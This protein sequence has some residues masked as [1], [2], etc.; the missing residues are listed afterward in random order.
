MKILNFIFFL[1]IIS[2][3]SAT[4]ISGSIKNSANGNYI[5]NAN[6]YFSEYQGGTISDAYGF[7]EIEVPQGQDIINIKNIGFRP[8]SSLLKITDEDIS[9]SIDMDPVFLEFGEI[10]VEGLFSTRL[11]Y[12]SAN[13]ISRDEFEPSER[14]SGIDMLR[15]LPGVEVQFAH[16]NGRN[17][18]LSIRGS[19]D[20]KPGGYNN[21]VLILLDGFPILIPNSGAIDWSSIPLEIIERIEVDNSPASAQYGHNSMGGVINLI[22]DYKDKPSPTT[23]SIGAGTFSTR[24][25]SFNKKFMTDNWKLGFNGMT[26][27]SNGH[28]NNS[29]DQLGRLRSYLKYNDNKGR[30]YRLSHIISSSNIGHPGFSSAPSFRRSERI[31]NYLQGHGFYPILEGLS[32]SH[33]VYINTFQTR[34]YDS[35]DASLD[36]LEGERF[37]NDISIGLRSEALMTRWERWIIMI[38]ADSDLS[39]SKVTVFNP[40]YDSLN[41]LSLGSFIQTKYSIGNGWSLGLGYRYDYRLT[42]PGN[43]YKQRTYSNHSPKLNLLYKMNNK[44]SFTISYSEGFRAPSL[45]ELYL[46]HI[47]SYGLIQ[48][49]NPDVLP[50]QVRAYEISYEHPHSNSWIWSLSTFFNKYENMIDFVYTLPV[51]A[52]NRVGVNG[53]GL[54]YQFKYIPNKIFSIS[55]QYSYLDMEDKEG[56]PVLYRSRHRAQLSFT[57]KTKF[58]DCLLSSQYWSEQYYDDF[59]SHDYNLVEDKVVFPIEVLPEQIIPDLVLSRKIGSLDLS[60]K[61]SNLINKKYELIQDYP[62]PGRAFHGKLTKSI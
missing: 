44:R 38:G 35:Q 54:E 4:K 37:Y 26:R 24:N 49:G 59:L 30:S 47:S 11:G 36:K 27:F 43:N 50:E 46:Q 17:A 42:D 29:D 41:Q 8:Y 1:I 57:L 9:L 58:I 45:S 53:K 31:S 19:S 18:N 12:E 61:I 7:F 10:S 23:F 32:M 6:I 16:P 2:N 14:Q 20:Y 62:M 33:S 55:G 48:Q 28:R 39:K 21:R 22:T 51:R 5:P 52:V 56:I 60:I 3:L 15:M 13:I 25:T 40:I 34:Y